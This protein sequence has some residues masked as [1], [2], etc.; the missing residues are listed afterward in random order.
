MRLTVASKF[1][2]DPANPGQT[3]TVTT[4]PTVDQVYAGVDRIVRIEVREANLYGLDAP[5]KSEVMA[6]VTGS[7]SATRNSTFGWRGSRLRSA[8]CS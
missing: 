2:P 8:I 4:R 6:A 7:R 3:R 5:K 1:D